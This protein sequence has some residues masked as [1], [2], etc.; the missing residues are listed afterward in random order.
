M[1]EGG[2]GCGSMYRSAGPAN[3][4]LRNRG[5]S[6][7]QADRRGDLLQAGMLGIAQAL[8]VVTAV[9]YVCFRLA[10]KLKVDDEFAAML[11][12]AARIPRTRTAST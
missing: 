12:T 5:L 1:R 3:H 2:G 9:W 8:L 10:R 7:G 11:A 4:S 6:D